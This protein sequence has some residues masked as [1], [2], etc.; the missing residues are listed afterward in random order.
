[1][2][3]FYRGYIKLKEDKTPYDN[4]RM[5]RHMINDWQT[6]GGIL[7]NEYVLVDI[8]TH[9]DSDLFMRLVDKYE[10]KCHVVAT[11]S[12]VHAIFKKPNIALSSV[13]GRELMCGIRADFKIGRRDFKS[14]DYECVIK[15]GKCRELL[16]QCDDPQI[17][18]WQ[19]TPFTNELDLKTV[20]NGDGRHGIHR[21][22]ISRACA[23]TTNAKEIIEFVTWVND[24]IFAVPRE[25]VNWKVRDVQDWIDDVCVKENGMSI[26]E[27][28]QH[29]GVKDLRKVKQFIRA[30]YDTSDTTYGI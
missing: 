28:L 23:Y 24:N 6:V 3:N 5:H 7:K 20:G 16:Q 25:S 30:N 14:S 29:Y 9:E 13:V 2:S 22:L 21:Q 26:D 11:D 19:L 10:W 18:P 12:G 17:L 8:D 27:M 1:M 15:H 4:K